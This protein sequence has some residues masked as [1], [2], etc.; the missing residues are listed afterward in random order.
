MVDE[1][2]KIYIYVHL[3]LYF[4]MCLSLH[5]YQSNAS[6]YNSGLSYLKARVITNQKH[7]TDSQNSKRKETQVNSRENHQTTKGKKQRELKNQ[8]ENKA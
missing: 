7:S 3:C 8:V 5:D 6:R 2:K 1:N 4:R